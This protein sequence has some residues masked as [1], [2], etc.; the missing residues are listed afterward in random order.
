MTEF[1]ALR[2]RRRYLLEQIGDAEHEIG[3]IDARLAFLRSQSPKETF[4][5]SESRP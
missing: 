2:R 1:E 3:R 4:Y 5:C